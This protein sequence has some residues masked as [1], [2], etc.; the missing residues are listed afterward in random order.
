VLRIDLFEGSWCERLG[1]MGA[2]PVRLKLGE[3]SYRIFADLFSVASK[4]KE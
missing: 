3:F 1:A 4:R 2:Q